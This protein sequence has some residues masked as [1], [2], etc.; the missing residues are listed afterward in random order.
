MKICGIICE[1][2]PFHNGH[3]YLIEQAKRSS[4]CD[5]VVCVMSGNFTQRG[6]IAL[7]DKY[8]RAKHAIFAGADAVLE[9][10]T[11]FAISPAEIFAKGA[12]KILSS[13][14]AFDTLAF[15]CE[16]ED[17][18]LFIEA[19]RETEAESAERKNVLR[20]QLRAGASLPKARTEA[21]V[22]TGREDLAG[23]LRKPNNILGTEYQKALD[24]FNCR[25]DILPI[26]RIGAAH[27]DTEPGG[28][29]SSA[30]AIRAA[31]RT[32]QAQTV[33]ESVPPFVREDIRDFTE[34]TLYKKIAH[35]SALTSSAEKLAKIVDCTEGLENRIK[36]CA[37]T[38]TG[39]D[40]L[41]T[42]A[43][44]KRY[45]SSR[46]RR[47]LAAAVLEICGDL[48]RDALQAP[49]YLK[50]LAIK[51]SCADAL[52]PEFSKGTFPLL[53]RRNDINALRGT[54]LEAYQKDLLA[55]DVYRLCSQKTMREQ[56]LPLVDTDI[57]S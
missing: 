6:E 47:I 8:A 55:D 51:K 22:K 5:L 40:E 38:A 20:E 39:C 21:L 33:A 46:I 15:G 14:P 17:R 4:G 29:F 26:R 50:L 54:A 44:T 31:M 48:V 25:A 52:L 11:I 9:L 36:S 49:L 43:T 13:L 37:K 18:Q 19:A 16:T 7:L 28:K 42:K 30:S 35:F 56:L 32:G 53:A 41:I 2:N 23:F 3:A 27:A 24:Y 57:D 1:Y 45:I 10:P 34:D 12:V